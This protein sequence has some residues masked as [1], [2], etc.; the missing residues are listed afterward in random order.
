VGGPEDPRDFELLRWLLS[1][2]RTALFVEG[3][4][5]FL[6]VFVR[7]P[8]LGAGYCCTAYDTRPEICREYGADGCD[9]DQAGAETGVDRIVRSV[10]EL[11]AYRV[12]WAGHWEARR[13]AAAREAAPRGS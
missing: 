2:E 11:G 10:E 8:A 5:W 7:C 12:A 6:R 1:H 4:T 13:R 9:R 3:R